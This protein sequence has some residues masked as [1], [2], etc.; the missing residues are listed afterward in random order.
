M[1]RPL[2]VREASWDLKDFDLEHAP[3]VGEA[4]QVV[5][6]R[7]DE[8]F[9]GKVVLA[10]VRTDHAASPATLRAVLIHRQPLHVPLVG[11]GHRHLFHRREGSDVQLTHFAFL[12]LRAARVG[13][14]GL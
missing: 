11:D 1:F 8:D 2:L 6:R 7:G 10:E 14:L 9:F 12:H 4:Q 5:V 13:V 3:G